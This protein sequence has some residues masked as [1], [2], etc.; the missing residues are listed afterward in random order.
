[1]DSRRD[2]FSF[3]GLNIAC[4]TE[5]WYGGGAELSGHLIDLKGET[6][7]RVLHKS[8]GGRKRKSGGGVAIAFDTSSCNLK[9]R[10]LKHVEKGIEIMCQY[11]DLSGQDETRWL[12]VWK[13]PG[14]VAHLESIEDKYMRKKWM[15]YHLRNAGFKGMQ[16]F[17]LYCCHIR[18]M[19]EYYSPVYH[20]LLNKGQE[21]S[22]KRLKRHAL[23]VCFG[24]E[25]PVEEWMQ[26]LN[27]AT[28][29]DRRSRRCD[30]FLKKAAS[31]P[32]FAP[33]WFPA[34]EGVARD[35]R[36]GTTIHQT[37]ACTLRRFNPPLAFLR[38]RANQLGVVP[39]VW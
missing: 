37:Q 11:C 9:T 23:R 19:I 3:L 31:N 17:K 12:H 38:R 30:A 22:L 33:S 1:M 4:V 10:N 28:L 7:I 32:L 25:T 26:Q 2:A 14:A 20:S 36:R 35:L 6:G 16:L 34:R 27:I 5:T 21:A 24:Y 13:C 39:E 18:S 15:L 29:K 8:R